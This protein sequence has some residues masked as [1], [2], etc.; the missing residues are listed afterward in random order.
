MMINEFLHDIKWK[1]LIISGFIALVILVP[2]N[3][4][5]D[6]IKME[7]FEY[8]L[9]QKWITF[10]KIENFQGTGFF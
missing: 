10:P 9:E 8:S 1:H 4:V 7:V 6:Y 5:V 2:L 3:L